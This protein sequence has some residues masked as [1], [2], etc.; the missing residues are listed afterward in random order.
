MAEKIKLRMKTTSAGPDG[1]MIEGREYDVDIKEAEVLVAGKYAA[2][3]E[4]P[5]EKKE[6]PKKETPKKTQRKK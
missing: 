3:V 4:Q 1:V 2:Y 5:D 6:V